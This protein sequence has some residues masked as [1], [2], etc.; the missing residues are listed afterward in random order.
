MSITDL[1]TFQTLVLGRLRGGGSY[2]GSR[3]SIINIRQ[4]EHSRGYI[5]VMIYKIVSRAKD[6]CRGWGKGGCY[7]DTNGGMGRGCPCR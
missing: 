4:S 2:G 3:F 6:I 5:E 1:V 7:A